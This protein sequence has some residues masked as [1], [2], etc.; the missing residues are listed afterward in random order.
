MAV[1]KVNTNIIIGN[2][3]KLSSYLNQ[4]NIT[5][6]LV[7]KILNG[8]RA[9]LE[10]ILQD[11]SIKSTHSVGDSRIS[12]LKLIKQ[13]N[14]DIVT[15]YIKPPAV[16]L[17]KTIINY[18]DISL[19]TSYR[20]IKALND[21]AGKA[22]KRHRVIVMIELGELR[23]GILREN[24][25]SFY[26]EI[27]KLKNIV[28][29]G[30][31][32][33]LGCM[34]GVEPTYDKLI[35]LNLYKML[36]EAKFNKSLNLVSAGSSITLPLIN[37]QKIPVGVNHFR[38]GESAFMGVSP[39]DNKKFM[40]LS[41]NAFDF[42][43]EVLEVE[44][45]EYIPDGNIGDA[46]IGSTANLQ[47]VEN[48]STSYRAIVDFGELDVNAENIKPKDKNVK[49]FGTTS[50]MTVYDIGERS[51][52]IKVGSQIHFNPNYMAVARLMNSKYVAKIVR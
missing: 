31:G 7:T 28:V 19:N 35:Q 26:E 10:R 42:S 24:I 3:R 52:K 27:F 14:P 1:L 9:I 13:I 11:N 4:N 37:Q 39:F 32:T 12:N 34:Y 45:K 33:N 17:A 8:N 2:I 22:G 20:T 46:S 6:S 36:I 15:M 5:W 29:E 43:A 25:L 38:I 51:N 23:E 49:F 41:G 48:N 16:N 18:V 47:D 30:I 44:K 21:E 50:D 40:N